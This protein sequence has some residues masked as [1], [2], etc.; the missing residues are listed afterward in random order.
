MSRQKPKYNYHELPQNFLPDSTLE[1]SI[2]YTRNLKFYQLE[3]LWEYKCKGS[4]KI[5]T[6]IGFSRKRNYV[7]TPIQEVMLI[8][9]DEN[10]R[11]KFFCSPIWLR[12]KN[13]KIIH[14]VPVNQS[15][16]IN[17]KPE[18]GWKSFTKTHKIKITRDDYSILK[19]YYNIMVKNKLGTEHKYKK[20]LESLTSN[21]RERLSYTMIKY[22][23]V[24]TVWKK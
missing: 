23:R 19:K 17:I 16:L 11:A 15:D 24:F 5:H 8:E 7:T 12:R 21:Q 2:R 1:K 18:K 14:Y 6:A 10:A 22:H 4:M 20:F 13:V 3:V 9:A